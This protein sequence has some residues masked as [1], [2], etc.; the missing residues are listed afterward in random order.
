M[1]DERNVRHHRAAGARWRP[2]AILL[3]A[4]LIAVSV[5][6]FGKSVF[7]ADSGS[8]DSNGLCSLTVLSNQD[9]SDEDMAYLAEA[10]VV[11]DI[12]RIAEAT[13]DKMYDTYN[14]APV[15]SLKDAGLTLPEYN[16]SDEW[17]A[18]TQ[19]VSDKILGEAPGEKT[20][21]AP[22]CPYEVEKYEGVPLG[23]TVS[24]LKPGIYF[25]VARGSN[26][27]EYASTNKL[28]DSSDEGEPG[29]PNYMTNTVTLAKSS[30]RTYQFATELVMVPTKEPVEGVINSAN[31][32][33]W[34]FDV[35]VHL[36][37]AVLGVG[38]QLQITKVLKTYE[39]RKKTTGEN[40]RD[41]MDDATFVFEVTAYESNAEGAPVIYHEFV[42]MIFDDAAEKKVIIDDIPVGAYVVVKEVY[43]GKNYEAT[44]D[45]KVTDIEPDVPANVTFEN[46]YNDKPG[47]GGSVTNHFTFDASKWTVEQVTDNSTEGEHVSYP[48][49]EIIDKSAESSK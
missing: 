46:D 39:Y 33:D 45:E 4:V 32:G 40:P 6:F 16:N 7:A 14:W 48:A 49:E 5:P 43:S 20:Q 3:A 24:G 17:R 37:P 22:S 41:I 35:E 1:K 9:M 19:E 2:A 8:A 25:I 12:Y 38:G 27:A 10:N 42:S 44:V 47:G 36:K 18:K 13:K 23:E 21:W 29:S 26:V 28:A 31:P 30:R 34:I 11:V 15:Q